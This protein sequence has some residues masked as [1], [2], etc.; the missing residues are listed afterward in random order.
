MAFLE[1]L[2]TKFDEFKTQI[3]QVVEQANKA[4]QN[5]VPVFNKGI[6]QLDSLGK[7]LQVNSRFGSN[8]LLFRSTSSVN[9]LQLTSYLCIQLLIRLLKMPPSGKF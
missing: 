6:Q 8:N 7:I 5:L 1:Q 9:N 2:R 4:K 3:P